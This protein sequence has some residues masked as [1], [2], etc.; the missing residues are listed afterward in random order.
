VRTEKEVSKQVKIVESCTPAKPAVL[1]AVDDDPE[2]LDK[3]GHELRKRYDADYRIAC[4]SS[5]AAATRRLEKLKAAGEEVALVLAD[6]WMPG[7]T[8]TEFLEHVQRIYPTAKRA[9]LVAW[10]EWWKDRETAEAIH[11]SMQ[12]GRIDYCV[13]KPWHSP[14]ELF[15]S[16]ISE[17]LRKWQRG[18]PSAIKEVCVVGEAGSPRSYE[19][20]NLLERN[21]ISHVFF[22]ADS[23]RGRELLARTRKTST[24]G[25]VVLTRDARVLVDPSNAELAEA[26]GVST[27]LKRKTKR[28]T[29]DVI[30]IGA[31]P[32]GLAAAVYGASEGLSTLV[33]EKEAVGGQAGTSSL[34]R[35]YLGF[36]HG[37][38]G[39]DLAYRAFQQGWLFG[40]T[41][42]FGDVAALRRKGPDLYVT[43]SDGTEVAG[44]TVIVAT[45]A[46]YR[47]LGIP[48]LEAL[49][50]VGVFYGAAVTEAQTVQGQRVHIVGAGNSAGQA[51][52]HLSKY[53]SRVTLLAHGDSLGASMSEYLIKQIEAAEN[54]EVRLNTRVIDG[55]GEGRL[56]RLVLENTVS[57][58]TETVPT[59]ALFVLIGA[60]PHTDWLPEEI[61]R[62][63][64]GYI[65]TGRD[66]SYYGLP[67]RE[68]HVKRLPLLL[69][70]SMLGVFA[71]GDVRHRSVKRVASACG[72]GSIGIQVVHEY[73]VESKLGVSV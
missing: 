4:E 18:R 73:L 41:F 72:E 66:L 40:A 33:V 1:L 32:A 17:F 12:L 10:G 68:W 24:R 57:G 54:V 3:I 30:I 2:A 8:G 28:K 26:F 62:D 27:R 58:H 51:T 25:P 38:G 71:A 5:V 61:Q 48:S 7:T 14:D 39:G 56:E 31:G 64:E 37:I 70:T 52:I 46:S 67:H 53:A 29:F 55:G 63:E 43:L 60:K 34:I 9:L 65:V 50:G 35:N 13:I 20:R 44:R 47:R 45:G 6:Q 42:L 23:E 19:V 22:S 49:Q 11:R 36:P 69:E 16:T 21:S 15:H 59:A